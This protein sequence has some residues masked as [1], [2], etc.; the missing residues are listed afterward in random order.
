MDYSEFGGAPLLWVRGCCIICHGRSNANAMKNAIRVA[1]DFSEGNL[2]RR[3]EDELKL[4]SPAQVP[5]QAD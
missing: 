1:K 2:N 5:A 3:I 4:P